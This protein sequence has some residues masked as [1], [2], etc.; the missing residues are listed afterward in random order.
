MDELKLKKKVNAGKCFERDFIKSFPEH[1]FLHRFHDSASSWQGGEG[2][3]F[4]PSSICDFMIYAKGTYESCLWF[5]EL[6]SHKGNSIPLSCIRDKQFEGLLKAQ[7]KGIRAG[8]V[9]NF[10]DYNTTYLASVKSI[11]AFMEDNDRKSIPREWLAQYGEFI[12]QE[13]KHRG[14]HQVYNTTIFEP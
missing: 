6:K 4:T 9:F 14:T 11:C 13:V 7:S 2:A 5:L 1:W 12:S 8:F 3:R 10:R